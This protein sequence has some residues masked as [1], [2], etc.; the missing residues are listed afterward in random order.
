MKGASARL[1]Q[2]MTNVA[3][4]GMLAVPLVLLAGAMGAAASAA[5]APSGEQGRV[6]L[7]L[8]GVLPMPEGPASILVL[9]EKGAE[10]LLPLIVPD[11]QAFGSGDAGGAHAKGGLLAR[12]IEALGGRV[13]E[14]DID[15][16]HE[17][18]AGARVLVAQGSRRLE[19]RAL[20][21]ESVALALAA[22]VP[23]VTTRRLLA[24]AGLTAEDLARAHARHREGAD[25]TRL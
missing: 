3:S 8:A 25:A 24:E 22:G 5:R 17:T 23:I 1:G 10:T 7:E 9:R 12:A 16:A 15:E 19:L 13:S 6:E 11:G 14:V 4:A 18:S 20:P 21:S 2:P